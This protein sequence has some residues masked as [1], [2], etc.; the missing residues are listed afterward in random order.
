[1]R[2]P[3][4]VSPIAPPQFRPA[5][6]ASAPGIRANLRFRVIVAAPSESTALRVREVA[7][8]AFPTRRQGQLFLQ[9]GAFSTRDRANEQVQALRAAGFQPI[10]ESL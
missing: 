1:N 4:G 3:P 6:P 7:P 5:A 2:L 9:T 10:V 8:N